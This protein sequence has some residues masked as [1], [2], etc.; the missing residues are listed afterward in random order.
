MKRESLHQK[1]FTR[2]AI[3]LGGL[4]VGLM[5]V[6]AGRLYY[7][8]VVQ[9]DRY[10]LQSDENR[11][12][13]RLLAPRRGRILDRFGVELA[14]NQQN[15]RVV[16][17]AEQAEDVEETL[18][19][20]ER[21]IPLTAYEKSK[22]LRE[23]A[24]R[25]S[26]VPVT[27]AENLSWDE[28]ARINVNSPDLPGLQPEIGE[29]RFYPMG[30]PFS[31]VVGYISAVAVGD[32]TGDPVL[33]LPGYKIGKN[34]IEKSREESLRGTAGVSR[35][36][37][38]AF[39]RVIRELARNEG[40]PGEDI[41]LTL[42]AELQRFVWRRLGEESASAAL[43][44]IHSGDV[45]SLVSS[46][47]FDPQAFT[48]G[49]TGAEWRSLTQDRRN[50]L[51]NKAI[52][53]QYPPG[54]TFKLVVALAALETGVI[55]PDHKVTCTGKI[56][57]GNRTF[58]CWKRIGH[59]RLDLLSAIQQSCDIYFYDIA[60]KV[61][62]DRIAAMA[63]RLGLGATTGI[64]LLGEKPGLIPTKAWKQASIGEAWRKSETM[65]AG[66]GQGFVLT[67]ALQLA[68]M[69]ARIANGGSAVQPQI[70]AP[71]ADQERA[72][73]PSLGIS[74]AAINIVL[75][76]MN[77]VSN[78][79]RGTGFRARIEDA[80][81]ALAGKSGTSQVRRIS[82]AERETRVLRNDERAWVER[83]HALFVAYAPVKK[84]RYAA[85]V[86]VEHGG[87]GSGVAAPIV[88]DILFEVQRLAADRAARNP[89]AGTVTEN[90]A[91]EGSD[92]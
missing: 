48:V 76:G 70:V 58:H 40:D 80:D 32:L 5:S 87:S 82:K 74:R 12:N 90:S 17:I 72:P 21:I 64:G 28:F 24:R 84:P 31:H 35:V 23:V 47:G 41:Q 62:V 57:F 67:T 36:E 38:N 20:L 91:S 39:G 10:S 8:Q 81:F 37:V 56:E 43:I 50:P 85:A 86:I 49:L 63:E 2:R 15:F 79:P 9:S 59:G 30:E 65:I 1:T 3:M 60:L 19:A 16:L 18:A 13:M 83:D 27:V 45:L 22:V 54:S 78:S 77:R 42:D 53:G 25:R 55:S 4:Q 6:L 66:I 34:G 75:E 92:G 71:V 52:G 33:E 73:A 14:G 26:F 7:L 89:L 69:T 11:I 88:R 61:G 44:E 46:P 29:S 68:V 51:L